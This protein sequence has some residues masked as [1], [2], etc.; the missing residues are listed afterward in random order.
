MSNHKLLII[1]SG[2]SSLKYALYN[3][4]QEVSHHTLPLI[5][6]IEEALQDMMKTIS[7][8]SVTAIGHRIVFG[9]DFF[10]KPIRID[11]DALQKL[12]ALIPFAP[13]H[14]PHELA[15][16]DFFQKLFPNTPQIACFDTT[17]HQT[18]PP[19]AR[20]LGLPRSLHREGVKRYGFHGLSF[21]S[22][23]STLN[24][25]PDKVVIAHLGSGNSVCAIHKGKSIDTT[26][27]ISPLGGVLM[28][29]RTGDLDPGSILY[30]LRTKQLSFSQLENLLYHESGWLGLSG[31]SASMKDLLRSKN[32][33][34]QEAIEVFCY[35]IA[36]AIGAYY[37]TLAGID[38]LIFTGGIGANSPIICQKITTYL[39]HLSIGEIASLPTQEEKMIAHHTLK[40]LNNL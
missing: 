30:L 22:I 25:L 11:N 8:E 38:Q 3:E 1:N 12:R 10:T 28:A 23:I 18:L 27:G 21:E 17:F 15:A 32:P 29:T 33:Q 5:N 40:Y 34:S 6:S 36:K 39:D 13:L 7:S 31:E 4:L 16:V 37:V 14:M 26:M 35:S 19:K 2:S 24:P 20:F 9:G